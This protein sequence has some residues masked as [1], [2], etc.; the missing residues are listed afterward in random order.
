MWIRAWLAGMHGSSPF[1]LQF[2]VE[3]GRLPR[4]TE[5]LWGSLFITFRDQ[6]VFLWQRAE[7]WDTWD[8]PRSLHSAII[9]PTVLTAVVMEAELTPRW[10]EVSNKPIDQPS[11]IASFCELNWH[12]R[13]SWQ[14]YRNHSL[15]P[16]VVQQQQEQHIEGGFKSIWWTVSYFHFL[17]RTKG[18]N[19]L[20]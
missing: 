17:N 12:K 16:E 5:G 7:S 20:A 11:P 10:G 15:C 4:R 2:R 18:N 8:P 1:V 6:C 13:S 3:A 14:L 9:L 19:D